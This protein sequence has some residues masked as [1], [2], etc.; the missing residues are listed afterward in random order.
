MAKGSHG[1]A[2]KQQTTAQR[3][4]GIIKS[5]RRIMRKDKGLSTDLDR[6]PMLTW[7]MFLKLLDDMERVEEVNAEL[8]QYR[9]P[10]GHRPT[11]SLA[12]LGGSI[13]WVDG[14][15]PPCL[16]GQRRGGRAGWDA[17]VRACSRICGGCAGAAMAPMA[18]GAET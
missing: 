2:T 12:G 9:V 1:T 15:R 16:S 5:A 10:A 11:L 3:L 17:R 8:A 13:G 18:P 4:D 6:L 14:F 7:I